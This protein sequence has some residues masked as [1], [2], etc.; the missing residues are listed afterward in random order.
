MNI[1]ITVAWMRVTMPQSRRRRRKGNAVPG[2]GGINESPWHWRTSTQVERKA[3]D[4]ALQKKKKKKKKKNV[5]KCKDMET[6]R[7]N[8]TESCKEGYF[9]KR[10]GFSFNCIIIIIISCCSSSSPV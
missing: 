10:D 1:V 3:D 4:L 2:D 6:G 5:V 7:S 8:L 9:S